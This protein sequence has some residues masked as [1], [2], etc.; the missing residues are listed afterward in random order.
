MR[1]SFSNR[2]RDPA[3]SITRHPTA[4]KSPSTAAHSIVPET[5]SAKT[6]ARVRLC[7]LFMLA[8][9]LPGECL[10]KQ[11]MLARIQDG[12]LSS[13]YEEL[14]GSVGPEVRIAYNLASPFCSVMCECRRLA[15]VSC[16]VL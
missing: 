10:C 16:K 7:L 5:G 11:N 13:S 4:T 2:T 6:A 12:A 15:L 8:V 3:P 9:Y 14:S 1:P